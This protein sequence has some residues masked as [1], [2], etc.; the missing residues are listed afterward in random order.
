MTPAVH[1]LAHGAAAVRL[2]EVRAGDLYRRARSIGELARIVAE[3]S[4][5]GPLR[6]LARAEQLMVRIA[7]LAGPADTSHDEGMI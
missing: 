1:G 5:H 3:C 2:D 7:A 6:D 4:M